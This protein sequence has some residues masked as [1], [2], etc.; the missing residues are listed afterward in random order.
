MDEQV[1][2]PVDFSIDG[3]LAL[4]QVMPLRNHGVRSILARNRARASSSTS[5]SLIVA[6]L[7]APESHAL[8]S[9]PT[10]PGKS[11]SDSGRLVDAPRRTLNLRVKNLKQRG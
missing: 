9:L 5:S 4:R 2:K 1:P 3:V 7:F 8:K 11:P 6:N 10:S